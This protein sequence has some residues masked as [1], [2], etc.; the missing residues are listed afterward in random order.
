M[1]H[2]RLSLK[3]KVVKI[4]FLSVCLLHVLLLINNANAE[5]LANSGYPIAAGN[6]ERNYMISLPFHCPSV[7]GGKTTVLNQAWSWPQGEF[8]FYFISNDI[9]TDEFGY[10]YLQGTDGNSE[11]VIKVNINDGTHSSLNYVTGVSTEP[12]LTHVQGNR[13]YL[14]KPGSTA[15]VNAA[16]MQKLHEFADAVS[17][18]ESSSF[19]PWSTNF[20]IESNMDPSDPDITSIQYYDA[21]NNWFDTGLTQFYV[22]QP[23]LAMVYNTNTIVLVGW[24]PNLATGRIATSNWTVDFTES[25]DRAWIE[26]DTLVILTIEQY[27]LKFHMSNG[28]RLSTQDLNQYQG[29]NY[30]GNKWMFSRG[31]SFTQVIIGEEAFYVDFVNQE[32]ITKPDQLRMQTQPILSKVDNTVLFFESNYGFNVEIKGLEW[33]TWLT[34]VVGMLDDSITLGDS[35]QVGTPIV[36]KDCNVAVF[37]ASKLYG[38]KPLPIQNV[39]PILECYNPNDGRAFFSYN[40]LETQS[41]FLPRADD[42]NNIAP[43][44]T[45]PYKSF[46][47]G[48][49]PAYPLSSQAFLGFENATY[50]WQLE[51]YVLTFTVGPSIY[52]PQTANVIITLTADSPFP[53]GFQ[54]IVRTTFVNVTGISDSRVTIV[55]KR[56]AVTQ[57]IT[58]ETELQ[59]APDETNTEP[60]PS[61]VVQNFVSSQQDQFTAQLAEADGAPSNVQTDVTGKQPDNAL[62]GEI[63]PKAVPTA[64]VTPVSPNA[65]PNQNP[66]SQPIQPTSGA[67]RMISSFIFIIML[68]AFS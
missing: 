60:D 47:P 17:G 31:K 42:R 64:P 52:C 22:G 11:Q 40:N 44:N 46:A 43:L 5:T 50:T 13:F 23:L 16:D 4:G 59:I 33:G 26:D 54:E 7:S 62:Q 24:H 35:G 14:S 57:T 20:M 67:D 68:I 66:T 39:V 36:D 12:I 15:V 29:N 10:I 53:Q 58:L 18:T 61:T 49:G 19:V 21:Q 2:V 6:A 32:N 51:D 30:I 1:E 41:F 3:I 45:I 48:N 56:R 28:T 9:T 63:P 55:N 38:L 25:P 65:G 8:F 27:L 37:Y 34:K